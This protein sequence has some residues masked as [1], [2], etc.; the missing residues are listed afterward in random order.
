MAQKFSIPQFKLNRKGIARFLGTLEA[1]IMEIVWK[2]ETVTVQEACDR[3]GKGANY[4]TVMTVMNRLVEKGYL[5]R[6]K[7]SRAF[8]YT[9]K[10]KRE[11]F[12][13]KASH[14]IVTGLV[15][16]FG[17]LA[18]A[19]FVDVLDAIDPDGLSTLERMIR[20]RSKEH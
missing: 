14:Q 10:L 2:R 18:L 15:S 16:D 4:K 17:E 3:M 13:Q 7:V 5:E 8:V 11:E 9:A 12:L 1:R 6:K 20:E 19:Q